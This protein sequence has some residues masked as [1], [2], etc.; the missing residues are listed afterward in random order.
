MPDLTSVVRCA[1]HPALGIARVGNAPADQYYLA[2]EVPGTTADPAS[3]PAGIDTFKNDQG[4][5]RKEAARFRVYGYDAEGNVVGEIT[6]GDAEIT[7]QVHLANRKSGW[8]KFANAMDLKQYALSTTYRNA[9]VAGESRQALV[10]DPGPLEIAGRDQKGTRYR[11]DQGYVRWNDGP[12]IQVPLGEL[13]TDAEGRLLVLGGDGHSGSAFNQPPTTFANND[14]WYDDVSDGPVRATVT[15]PG[16]QTFEAEPAMVAVTPP[17]FGPGLYGVVT[18]YDVVYDLFVRQGWIEPPKTVLFWEHVFPIFERMVNSQ[19]V[20]GGMF[21]LFGPGSPGDLLEPKRLAQLADPGRGGQAERQRV[22]G[23]FRQPPPPWDEGGP[24]TELPPPQ[25]Q[26]L[27][28]FYG[29]GFGEY[30]GLAIDELALTPTQYGWLERWAAGDF[31]PGERRQP[32]QRLEDLPTAEQPRALD[33]TPLEDCL[34]G[35]FHPGIELTWPLRVPRMW[36]PPAQA[37][38]L[39]YRLHILPPGVQPQDDFGAVLTPQVCLGPS[40][41]LTASGP[42]TLTRWLGIPWQTDEASCLA[43]YDLS[44]YLPVPSFWAARVPNDVLPQHAFQQANDRKLS[45]PQRFKHL[46][47]RQFWLRDL[48][49]SGYSAR[50]AN[51][52]AEWNLLGIVAERP[53][54]EKKVPDGFPERWWVETER[55]PQFSAADPTWRQLL[56]I[57]EA[58]PTTERLRKAALPLEELAAE[59][60]RPVETVVHPRRRRIRQDER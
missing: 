9:T 46:G 16:G 35:P 13:R 23:W 33:R 47:H 5:V 57:E 7:W 22:F 15:L 55:S 25:P 6:A 26:K 18:M 59:Q 19:W 39:P 10:N 29:D 31:E 14:G 1:I 53:A 51:M 40:G 49:G 54:P 3:G 8:Y 37:G 4:E 44:T 2:P 11:F 30:T 17:N 32:P 20:N 41:P 43:G 52:V 36:R 38:G 27:P 56:M 50:I 34:G 45:E 28:P 48:Q 60:Q 42:G 58:E 21:F 12:P 24:R